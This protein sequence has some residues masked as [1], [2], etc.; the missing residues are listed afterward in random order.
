MSITH[1][2]SPYKNDAPLPDWWFRALV[3]NL[4]RS[5]DARRVV[6]APFGP[7]NSLDSTWKAAKQLRHQQPPAPPPTPHLKISLERAKR[8]AFLSAESIVFDVESRS[9]S[10]R[11]E[12]KW[13]PDFVLRFPGLGFYEEINGIA[14][15]FS[16][17]VERHR[18]WKVDRLC[19]SATWTSRSTDSHHTK[20]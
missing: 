14:Q 13:S 20:E 5:G 18:R 6:W 15:S 16:R 3:K 8:P 7:A 1:L 12:R 10:D 9:Y 2:V 11:S 17:L 19:G 4:W